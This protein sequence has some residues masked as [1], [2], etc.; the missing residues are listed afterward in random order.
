MDYVQIVIQDTVWWEPFP[1]DK[2][3]WS[4]NSK[5]E[6]QSREAL[7]SRQRLRYGLH[8]IEAN[9]GQRV[10]NVRWKEWCEFSAFNRVLYFLIEKYTF[11][12]L[13]ISSPKIGWGVVERKRGLGLILLL[14]FYSVNYFLDGMTLITKDEASGS[15]VTVEEA[16]KVLKGSFLTL[17]EL[18]QWIYFLDAHSFLKK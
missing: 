9:I 8:F 10:I 2:T 12:V 14:R 7:C 3:V 6:V 18:L 1:R 11:I 5:G 17:D 16:Q 15:S 13:K 4:E